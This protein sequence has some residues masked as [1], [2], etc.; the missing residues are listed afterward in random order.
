MTTVSQAVFVV[1][2]HVWLIFG[3]SQGQQKQEVKSAREVCHQE[4]SGYDSSRMHCKLEENGDIDAIERNVSDLAV[5]FA[6][7]HRVTWQRDL[8]PSLNHLLKLHIDVTHVEQ[9]VA[10]AL[11][12]LTS[13]ESLMVY[14][15]DH[16]NNAALV[17]GSFEGLGALRTINLERLQISQLNSGVF[18]GLHN[19]TSLDLN[20]NSVTALPR[21]VLCD[22]SK[23]RA[24]QLYENHIGDVNDIAFECVGYLRTLGLN[25][26]RITSL[27][28]RTFVNVSHLHQLNMESNFI[29]YIHPAAFE[30]LSKLDSL[31]LG[32]NRLTLVDASSFFP[33][34]WLRML[35][36]QK[37]QIANFKGVCLD[38]NHRDNCLPRLHTVDLNN[39]KLGP[40]LPDAFNVLKH[41]SLLNLSENSIQFINSELHQFTAVTQLQLAGNVLHYISNAAFVKMTHL[42]H[43]DVS[44]NRL[45]KLPITAFKQPITLK[46]LLVSANPWSCD[47]D[48]SWLAYW[49]DDNS[50]KKNNDLPLLSNVACV[51]V[52]PSGR[53]NVSV[54]SAVIELNLFDNCSSSDTIKPAINDTF[55]SNEEQQQTFS[56]IVSLMSIV[57]MATVVAIIYVLRNKLAKRC[58]WEKPSPTTP[59]VTSTSRH[60][61]SPLSSPVGDLE[62]E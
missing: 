53:A 2:V 23:L 25:S 39:N 19:L 11:R 52:T 18:W 34:K 57:V 36:M 48:F 14:Q 32:S 41:A 8:F 38:K 35:E 59:H 37:N 29:S 49:L 10:G 61:T 54:S 5:T 15:N 43:V 33:L 30:G 26:N 62:L 46:S 50:H 22:V 13:L 9:L 17:H 45:T 7:H 28:A 1:T 47:C 44:N 3:A 60:V 27:A 4:S 6:P 55:I 16:L 21:D 40:L 42:R 20:Y 31:F 12:L 58:Q 51:L 56:I 24:L